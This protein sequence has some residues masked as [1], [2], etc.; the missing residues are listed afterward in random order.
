MGPSLRRAMNWLEAHDSNNCGLLEIPESS[1]WMDLFPR[2]YNVLYD[3][4]LW[5]QACLDMAVAA[6][7]LGQQDR[8][9][10]YA[11]LTERVRSKILRQFWPTSHKTARRHSLLCRDAVYDW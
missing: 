4:V 7:V 8:A 3:E 1:D 6:E 11:R 9:V 2:S 5:Y 10:H